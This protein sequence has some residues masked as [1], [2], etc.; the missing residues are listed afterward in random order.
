MQISIYTDMEKIGKIKELL[1]PI[2]SQIL[3]LI[4]GKN[5]TISELHREVKN[6]KGKNYDYKAVYKQVKY[7]E[8]NKFIKLEKDK[9]EQGKPVKVKPLEK[10][11]K[12]VLLKTLL[13]E[14]LEK[15][16]DKT[17][18]ELKKNI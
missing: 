11:E 9:K 8:K 10:A 3:L 14:V 16:K 7:L 6:E 18:E 4:Y 13:E 5:R 2:Q 17:S 12:M 15:T 1:N